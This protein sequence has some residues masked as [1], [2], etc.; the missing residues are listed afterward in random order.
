MIETSKGLRPRFSRYA[1]AAI[2]LAL[3][4]PAASATDSATAVAPAPAPA[5]R[6]GVPV[7]LL[8][9]NDLHGNLDPVEGPAG[10]VARGGGAPVQAGGL[11]QLATLM[12]KS[13]AG[14][15]NSLTVGAG[16][17]IGGSPL[18]SALFHDE[19]T[20]H[21]LEQLG[22]DVTSV[23]NHEFDEGPDELKRMA[24]GGCHP[25]DGCA[26]GGAYDGTDYPYLAANVTRKGSTDPLLR[27]YTVKTL[28]GGQKIGFIGLITKDAPEAV[29]AAQI[30][31]VEFHDEIPVVER[32]SKELKE[33]GVDAQVL[34]IHEGEAENGAAGG[35][36]CDADEP[37]SQLR[38]RIKEIAERATSAVDL[39]VSGHS[40]ASYECTVTD[41]A[42][43]PRT[44]TQADSFGRSFTELRFDL[45]DSGDV[46]RRTVT[47]QN[48][49]VPVS[50][51][52]QPAMNKLID[53]WRERSATVANRTVGY[54]SA[55]IPGR[56][57]TTKET[58][59]GSLIADAQVEATRGYE[60]EVAVLTPGD[61]RADLV[62]K[63]DGAIT[64]ADAYRTQPFG[65]TLTTM[66]LTGEQLLDVLKEQFTGLN[67]R[68]PR[69]LQLSSKLR[70][71]LDMSRTGADRVLTDTVKVNGE[72]VRPT[73]KYRVTVS[74]FL[75]GGGD[76]FPTFTKGTDREG[77]E[78]IDLDALVHYLEAHSSAETPL[79][80]P[81]PGRITFLNG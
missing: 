71:S 33:Q 64:Y 6:A 40:H 65:T 44:V 68:N 56:G 10:Q 20:V 2:G 38:G 49:A 47:A 74:D 37:G 54:I 75:A 72:R 30:R 19:P 57:A 39:I 31:D 70:Y 80:P 25:E 79:A 81:A 29:N 50:T 14:R 17:M 69:I 16:D 22:L 7:Q 41:P 3:C 9:L 24:Y 28:P 27:P 11:P 15:P 55:D 5:A 51:P 45:D 62:H 12:D 61:L 66:T 73:A 21:A 67:A 34:L 32:Y 59:L 76:G 53:T 46:V 48:H 60:A 35:G 77:G 23:G 36:N 26:P 4:V 63:G 52:K 58:P 1:A 8:A 78:V 43:R 13:R 42:G 18:L